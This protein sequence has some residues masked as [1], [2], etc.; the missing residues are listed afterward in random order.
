MVFGLQFLLN[1]A[2]YACS[3]FRIVTEDGH[4]F[5]VFNFELGGTPN[6]EVGF[7]PKDTTFTASAPEGRKPASWSSR[8]A[9]TGMAW[10]DQQMMVGG[11]NEHGLAGANLNLPNYTQYQEVTEKDDGKVISAP[12]V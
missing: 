3:T 9:V 11:I 7:Y 1:P 5:F 8:Y 4:V 10:F 2:A 6:T 12:L